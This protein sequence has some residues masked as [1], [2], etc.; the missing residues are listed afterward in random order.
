MSTIGDTTIHSYCIFVRSGSE[1]QVAD[2]I[3]R[4]TTQFRAI[5]PVRTLQE[6]VQGQWNPRTRALLPGYIF[7]YTELPR[8]TFF[9]LRVDRMYKALR[10]STELRS[11]QGADHDYAMWVYRNHGNIGTSRVLS[12][13]HQVRVVDGP[14]LDCQGTIVRLDY[15]ARRA[16][17]AFDF[18]GNIRKVSLSIDIVSDYRSVPPTAGT[19][20]SGT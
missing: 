14:L 9:P 10:Y 20:T 4:S 3:N 13:G 5:A 12:R 18:D 1:Q 15:G 7:V 19:P 8:D 17:V 11:L 6:K 2:M 16:T